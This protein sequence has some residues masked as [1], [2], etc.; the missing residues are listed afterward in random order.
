MARI[1]VYTLTLKFCRLY[2]E[3]WSMRVCNDHVDAFVLMV[4]R[5]V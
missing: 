1:A 4:V 2:S 3:S 5:A